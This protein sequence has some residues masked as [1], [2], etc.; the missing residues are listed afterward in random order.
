M[1]TSE[2]EI[3]Y[4]LALTALPNIG[5]KRLLKTASTCNI[6]LSQLCQVKTTTLESIGWQC[7]QTA[8]LMESHPF[9]NKCIQWLAGDSNRAIITYQCKEYPEQLKQIAQAPL[10]LFTDGNYA[11]LSKPQL[12]VVGS[13]APTYNGLANTKELVMEVLAQSDLV[14]TSGLALGIDAQSHTA[15]LNF[16]PELYQ[17]TMVKGR[18]IGVL[19]NGI[20]VVYPKRHAQLYQQIRQNGL[21]VSEFP[22]SVM[23]S[24]KLF[25]RRNRIIS[26]LSLGTL[27]TEARIKSGSLITAKYALEQGR[28]VFAM[29]SN[30]N[31]KQAEGCHWLIKQ[32]AKLTESAQDILD[33]LPLSLLK[34]TQK[35][36]AEKKPKQNLATNG[37]LDSV[38]LRSDHMD[39]N[40][41]AGQDELDDSSVVLQA[42]DFDVTSIDVIAMRTGQSIST[43]FVQL[44]EYE[45][46]GFVTSTS[47][48]Y[49]KLRD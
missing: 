43:L 18:T 20:D 25:P 42:V 4:W 38:A 23:P 39:A 14:I 16:D 26:G 29:P 34:T 21:L 27:V 47:E 15:A 13:R 48:G 46:R 10:L 12:A 36:Q 5:I 33:E 11:L 17:N 31:N 22:P 28:E 41:C 6:T 8:C 32:G 9:T 35:Q 7:E 37:L 1:I 3:R 44:L 30:I 40:S 49:L 2:E 19:G 45:L 24:P